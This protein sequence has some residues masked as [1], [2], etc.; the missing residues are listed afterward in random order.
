[1][2]LS[3][4]FF[5]NHTISVMCRSGQKLGHSRF[6]ICAIQATLIIFI[7]EINNYLITTETATN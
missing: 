7:E 2:H 4:V 5:E 3:F 1:M 6:I